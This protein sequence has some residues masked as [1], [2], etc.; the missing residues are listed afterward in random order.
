MLPDLSGFQ[1]LGSEYKMNMEC[2]KW[3]KKEVIGEKV[4]KVLLVRIVQLVQDKLYSKYV[5]C[6]GE[7]YTM[8]VREVDGV[9]ILVHCTVYMY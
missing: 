5:H 1:L 2:Q 7:Q 9:S 8:W 4:I 6:T 3:Q